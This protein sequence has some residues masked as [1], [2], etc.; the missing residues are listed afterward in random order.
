MIKLVATN[1]V[2]EI[3]SKERT[4]SDTVNYYRIKFVFSEMWDTVI[5][6]AVFRHSPYGKHYKVIIEEDNTV[7]I[8]KEILKVVMPFEVGVM[9]DMSNGDIVNTNYV[10]IQNIE[11][12]FSEEDYVA[13]NPANTNYVLTT[14]EKIKYIRLNNSEFEYS[15]DGKVWNK[16][17][18]KTE[19]PTEEWRFTLEDGTEIVKKVV[20]VE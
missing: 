1:T 13:P 8:P 14:E 9:G 11:G 18:A 15:T 12:A 7:V 5:K 20:V 16:I 19:L 10:T 4:T 2:L 6:Y 17:S 3:Q